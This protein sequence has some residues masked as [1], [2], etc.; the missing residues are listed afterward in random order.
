MAP[1]ILIPFQE[2]NMTF[3]L[4]QDTAKE[5]TILPKIYHAMGTEDVRYPVAMEI[6]KN[7]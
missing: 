7:L 3:K 5:H 1:L 4:I 2:Q 6:K